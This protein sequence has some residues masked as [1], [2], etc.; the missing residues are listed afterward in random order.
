VVN[1]RILRDL[2]EELIFTLQENDFAAKLGHEI[3]TH[4]E[5]L[6]SKENAIN[7]ARE[8]DAVIK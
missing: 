4:F 8:T 6:P 7:L 1:N 3:I 5:T 2:R